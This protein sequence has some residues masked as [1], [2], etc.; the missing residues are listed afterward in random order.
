[1]KKKSSLKT[2]K[3]SALLVTIMITSVSIMFAIL[4]LERIIPYT[5][6]IRGME[7]SLQAYYQAKGEIELA[8]NEFFKKQI[9]E[10]IRD[11]DRVLTSS[12]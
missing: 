6:Q 4:L 7:D 11:V 8:K 10:N 2:E 1:M 5:R 9:R 3:G 12:H